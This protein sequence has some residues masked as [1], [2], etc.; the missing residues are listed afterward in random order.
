MSEQRSAAWGIEGHTIVYRDHRFLCLTCG[1]RLLNLLQFFVRECP[2]P[3]SDTP[4]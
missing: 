2:G 3:G 4:R 1:A